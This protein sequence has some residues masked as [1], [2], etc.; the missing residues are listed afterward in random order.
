MTDYDVIVVGAGPAG[1]AAAYDVAAAG[2]TVLLLDRHDFPRLKPCAGALT[3]KAVRALRYSIQPVVRRVVSQLTVTHELREETALRSRHPI[4]VMTVRSEFDHHCLRQTIATGAAFRRIA[5]IVGICDGPESVRVTTTDGELRAKFVV[6]ADGSN[7]RVRQLCNGTPWLRRALAIEARVPVV[8]YAQ[9]M[10]LDFGEAG[11]GYGWSF[12]KG[13][14]LNVGVYTASGDVK[15]SKN[16]LHRY[17]RRKFGEVAVD[18]ICG[19]YL[20]I[21]GER[22]RAQHRRI[23]FAGDAA[24]MA[25]PLSGEGIHNAIRSGQAVAQ[26]ILEDLNGVASADQAVERTMRPVIEDLAFCARATGKFYDH[27]PA[28]FAVIGV[29]GVKRALAKGYALGLTLSAIRENVLKLPFL[30][31]S[32]LELAG[33]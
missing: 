22:Y 6:A 27:L 17:I 14:H 15:L 29:P 10:A 26:A 19:Q 9:A 5:N 30:P 21:G 32:A 7:S 1:C 18:H 11:Y 28:G 12:H 3:V 8:H 31:V 24:G 25:D 16:E 23:L 13:D 20:G 2:R 4:C 33:D